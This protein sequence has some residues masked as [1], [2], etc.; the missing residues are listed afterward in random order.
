[1]QTKSLS[2]EASPV[3]SAPALNPVRSARWISSTLNPRLCRFRDARG[4]QLPG[5]VGRIVQHLD[6]EKL[7]R[8]IDLADR[9][10]QPLDHID[11]IE[12]RQLHRHFR[13]LLEMARRH[14][15]SLPVLQEKVDND[16]PMNSVGGKADQHTQV[17]DGPDDE[18]EA[19]LHNGIL[20]TA[21]KVCPE[22]GDM[23]PL[24]SRPSNQKSG[25]CPWKAE[26]FSGEKRAAPPSLA[27]AL[28][29]MQAADGHAS[30]QIRMKG[31]SNA[32]PLSLNPGGAIH[33][34]AR[35][36]SFRA[37]TGGQFDRA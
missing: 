18:A 3:S 32:A 5:V 13:Q 30:I 10:E 1:M 24:P 21:P 27:Q 14:H 15:S 11:F 4:R 19:S 31:I 28:P 8:V 6:L 26:T 35:H 23:M 22:Q 33:V 7:L 20:E 29:S 37:G 36:P 25:V 9:F 2:A 34:P 12:D 17:A 16:V